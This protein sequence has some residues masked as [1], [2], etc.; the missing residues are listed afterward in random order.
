MAVDATNSIEFLNENECWELLRSASLGRIAV[1]VAG[2]PEIF[3]VNF[4]VADNRILVHTSPGTKLVELTIN[5]H[6]A[7]ET[8]NIGAEEAWS[9]VVKG[10]ARVLDTQSEIDAADKLSLHS[11]M[12]TFKYV[13]VEI[14]PR[15]ITG[16]RF[17]LG[18]EPTL[19]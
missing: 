9:V 10:T 8:D 17:P 11:L 6:V 19:Y 7:F 13:Y 1:A 14:A 3:P 5:D 16:R 4:I 15:E 18:P 2:E 12:P